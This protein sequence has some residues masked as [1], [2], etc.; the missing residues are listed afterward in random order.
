MISHMRDKK[1]NT[2]S[3]KILIKLLEI[4]REIII[5][6]FRHRL[7]TL[8]EQKSLNSRFFGKVSSLTAKSFQ[9]N[10]LSKSFI[11]INQ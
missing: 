2:T 5:K 8:E 9:K 7:N 6:S 1:Y 4:T 10:N 11:N 3:N